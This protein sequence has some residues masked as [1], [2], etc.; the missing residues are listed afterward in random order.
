MDF[1]KEAR[2]YSFNSDDGGLKAIVYALLAINE[3]LKGMRRD[4]F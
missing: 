4:A 1:E 3:T 2:T